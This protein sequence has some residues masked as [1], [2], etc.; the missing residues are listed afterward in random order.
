MGI[1]QR[2]MQVAWLYALWL[3]WGRL[4]YFRRIALLRLFYLLSRDA[5]ALRA[6]K[7]RHAGQR[8]FIIGNG[9]SLRADDLE[10]L[11]GEVT[12][13]FNRIYLMFEHTA[14]RPTYYICEDRKVIAQIATELPQVGLPRVFLSLWEKWDRTVP[15]IPKVTFF[16]LAFLPSY[17]D[18]PAF[19]ADVARRAVCGGT[20]AYT[21]MQ[22][23]AYMGF[24]EIYLLGVDHSFARSMNLH[25]EVVVDP[26]ARDYFSDW[27]VK[28]QNE[29]DI[30]RPERS[31]LAYVAA[32]RY[33]DDH[34]I[35]ICNATRGGKLE[36][37]P[38]VDFDE[39]VPPAV[40]S[41]RSSGRAA[42]LSE[43][44]SSPVPPE[45]AE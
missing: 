7:G 5:I 19:S 37:F 31:A 2:V 35:A 16:D 33:A 29:L 32:K 13:A 4:L 24:A 11:R 41:P 6:L 18:P 42:A 25:G 1:K 17:P 21:A 15:D 3:A 45:S 27:Y 23:A 14:W 36:V 28:D 8:C 30:P 10:R 40:E 22:F 9:P 26:S 44:S 39:V 43:N 20:V 12:F 34:G 38:R